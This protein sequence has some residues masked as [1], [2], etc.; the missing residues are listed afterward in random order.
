[1]NTNT[2]IVRGSLSDIAR[3]DNVGLAE[4]FLGA[5]AIVLVDV[6]SSMSARDLYDDRS[7]YEAACDELTKL[8]ARLPGKIAVIAFSSAAQFC[9]NGT[10]PFFGGGTNMAGALTFVHVADDC[11]I[12]FVLISD[13]EPN[14]EAATLQVA[15]QFKSRIDTIFIG[16]EG[17][18]GV[19]FLR[20][21]AAATGGQHQHNRV[22]Q[23]GTTVEQFLLTDG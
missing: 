6:S 21:L 1:M 23:I 19:K 8:Q 22:D 3:Q 13:G 5:D 10:P 12:Q 15:R 11:G 20:Q 18:H 7:R 2:G 17:E 9:P 16:R 14:D 4:S